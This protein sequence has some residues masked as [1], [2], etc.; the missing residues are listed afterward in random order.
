MQY[1]STVRDAQNE[2]FETA[3]G[4][5][6]ILRV[7]NGTMPANT[8]A[9]LAGTNKLLAQGTLPADWMANSSGGVKAKLGTWTLAGQSDAGSGLVGTFFRLFASDGTTCKAQGTFGAATSLN[10]SAATAANN[11]VLTFAATTGVAVGQSISGTGVQPGT[12]VLA[13]TGTT[14]T[15][16]QPTLAG[17]ASGAAITFGSELV[18]DNAN[19]ANGQTVTISAF[20]V[21]RGN[22]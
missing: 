20:S 14:V 9:A 5:S 10:T 3:V 15:M 16:S 18:A 6:P 13:L 1:D 19:I 7:Y 4:A 11:N 12:T 21:T 17:V 8:S 22:A 2:A